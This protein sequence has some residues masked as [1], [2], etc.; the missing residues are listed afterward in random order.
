MPTSAL[1]ALS[2]E[3][4]FNPFKAATEVYDFQTANEL[5]PLAVQAKKEAFDA[6][7][8]D[9]GNNALADAAAIASVADPDDAP[10]IWDEQMGKLA[11]SGVAG[12]SQYV[13]H[14][15]PDLA[16]RVQ[17]AFGPQQATG[18]GSASTN[19]AAQPLNPQQATALAQMPPDKQQQSLKNMNM[20]IEGFN[21]VHDQQSW[22]AELDQLRQAGIPVDQ[23]LPNTEYNPLN[24]RNAYQAIQKLTPMRDA[25]QT[26]QTDAA[27]GVNA[28][29]TAPINPK[30]A[31]PGATVY[32]QNTGKQL[33]TVPN[34]ENADQWELYGADKTGGSPVLVNKRTGAWKD[35][36]TGTSTGP[37]PGAAGGYQEFAQKMNTTVENTTGNPAAKN[38]LST[39]TG[40][41]QFTEGTFI[42]T[43][44][45][46]FPQL[47]DL[48]DDKVLQLRNLPGFSQDMTAALAEQNGNTLAEHGYPVTMTTVAM[49]HQLGIGDAEKVLDAK[50][51][52]PLSQILSQK[53]LDANPQYKNMTAGQYSAQLSQKMGNQPLGSNGKSPFGNPADLAPELDENSAS[54]LKQTGLPF[55]AFMWLTGSGTQLPRDKATRAMAS[56]QAEDWANANGGHDVSSFK[57]QYKAQNDVL[58]S[59]IKRYNQTK[60]MENE[61]IG[62]IQNTAE[63]SNAAGLANLTPANWAEVWSGKKVNNPQIQE[64][65]G[66]LHQ[67]REELAGYYA[68]LSGR[69]SS[70]GGGKAITDGDYTRAESVI[71]NGITAKGMQGLLQSVVNSTGKMNQV[72]E[73]QIDTTNK[74][75]WDMFGVGQNYKPKYPN[76]TNFASQYTPNPRGAGPVTPAADGAANARQLSPQDQQAMSWLA[77]NPN[78]PRADAIRKRLGQ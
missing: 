13:G 39:A 9:Y 4:T 28:P 8:T 40:N 21:N 68:A 26:A 32:D 67:L 33:F 22:D 74:N 38:P 17:S 57:T 48:P 41:G 52:T 45:K 20:A 73:N 50:Q 10:R 51:D 25:L 47:A 35:P 54:I 76:S 30:E 34:K 59:N 29:I 6:A 62:T 63:A 16:N 58:E 27:F 69:S 18:K 14:Y 55:N 72:L 31:T 46:A 53:V 7:H 71:E 23:F 36:A 43:A 56:K 37:G 42:S 75:I 3:P 2:V 12:A 65:T 49:A 61:V 5:R 64:Y 77:D 11:Q 70:S 44:R 24:Y 78:D 1:P 15:R 60:I 19:P 66:D